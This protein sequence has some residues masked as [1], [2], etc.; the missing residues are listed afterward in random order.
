MTTATAQS[1]SCA[2]CTDAQEVAEIAGTVAAQHPQ[3][4][5]IAQRLHRDVGDGED[6]GSALER[7]RD[8]RRQHEAAE[9]Q[10][11][12]DDADQRPIRVEPVRRPGG[13]DPRPPHR[14]HQQTGLDRAERRQ[15]VQQAVREL[16]DR[17]DEDE[18]EEQLDEGHAMMVVTVTDP[19]IVAASESH[20][21]TR[22]V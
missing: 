19:Q 14:D 5:Q 8:R 21:R 18:I 15:M 13:V 7:L 2:S 16:G 20:V 6:D 3:H 12:Q 1:G 4:E 10:Q 17:E 9:H 22:G 11:E